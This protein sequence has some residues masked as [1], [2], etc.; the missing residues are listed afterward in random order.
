MDDLFTNIVIVILSIFSGLSLISAIISIFFFT[1][2]GVITKK[3]IWIS[4]ILL[5]LS[6]LFF[7]SSL[8]IYASESV[9]GWLFLVCVLLIIIATLLVVHHFQLSYYNRQRS[10]GKFQEIAD[11]L[12]AL[13]LYEKLREHMKTQKRDNN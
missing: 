1:E 11:M 2:G 3:G 8:T 9:L 7:I 12:K 13:S 10:Q 5:F 6:G 4:S